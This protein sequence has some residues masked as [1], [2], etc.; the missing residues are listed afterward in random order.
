[1]A[2]FNYI[3]LKKAYETTFDFADTFMLTMFMLTSMYGCNLSP[4]F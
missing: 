2:P 1:M 4:F 3:Y